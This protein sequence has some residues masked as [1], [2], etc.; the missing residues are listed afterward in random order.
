[1]AS[2]AR[3]GQMARRRA[4]ERR[5]ALEAQTKA[6]NDRVENWT[7]AFFTGVEER[8][9]ALQTVGSAEDTMADALIGMAAE[10]LTTSEVAELCEVTIGEVH[11]LIKRRGEAS[12]AAPSGPI[13]PVAMWTRIGTSDAGDTSPHDSIA[14]RKNTDA[15][16]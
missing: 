16:S 8:D 6:R 15:A 14:S 2:T 7:A 5:I 4:R 9:R 11:K 1:M 10:G 13:R 12:R 3:A